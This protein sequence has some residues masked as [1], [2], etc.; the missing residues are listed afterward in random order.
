MRLPTLILALFGL[1]IIEGLGGVF[2]TENNLMAR[3]IHLTLEVPE[4]MNGRAE[5][6]S[7]QVW[8][9]RVNTCS[10]SIRLRMYPHH[11]RSAQQKS[12]TMENLKR[13]VDGILVS[14]SKRTIKGEPA[15]LTESRSE[16]KS[17]Q[18]AERL[19]HNMALCLYPGDTTIA[20]YCIISRDK[21][22]PVPFDADVEPLRA[23]LMKMIESVSIH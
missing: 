4:G 1:S 3:G 14:H 19:Q 2:S 22:S 23:A 11:M 18:G 15:M 21:D 8:G 17:Y 13:N 10:V 7:I 5:E 6:S 9:C 12:D 16:F 20:L